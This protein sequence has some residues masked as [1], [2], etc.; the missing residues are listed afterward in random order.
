MHRPEGSS[1]LQAGDR[2][3][4]ELPLEPLRDPA[5]LFG[6]QGRRAVVTGASSG[7]GRRAALVLAM[8][9]AQVLTVA[10]RG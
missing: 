3:G 8:A 7:I 6:L 2:A 1:E 9:G 10:R 5:E 4:A